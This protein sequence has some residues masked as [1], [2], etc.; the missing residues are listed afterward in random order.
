MDAS[1][2]IRGALL[3]SGHLRDTCRDVQV[4]RGLLEEVRLCRSAFRG[5]CDVFLHSWDVM[6]SADSNT[7][8]SADVA[9]AESTSS[10]VCLQE[11]AQAITFAAVTIERQKLPTDA[12]VFQKTALA[13]TSTWG[14]SGRST[15]GYYMNLMGQVGALELMKRHADAMQLQYAAAVRMR[16]DCA[17]PRVAALTRARPPWSTIYRRARASPQRSDEAVVHACSHNRSLG[18]PA[19]DNCYWSAPPR[20]MAQLILP[21]SQVGTFEARSTATNRSC[22]KAAHPESLLR[23]ALGQSG[24]VGRPSPAKEEEEGL[25]E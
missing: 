20:W 8:G 12:G 5:A 16:V 22:L 11:L 24:V 13:G 9:T 14:T 4:R 10:F 19:S 18:S 25:D 15:H 17:S 6:E 2:P 7:A 1:P 3:L 23:C 21:F